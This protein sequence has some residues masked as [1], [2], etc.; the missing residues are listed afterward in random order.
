MGRSMRRSS[1]TPPL[2]TEVQ[3]KVEEALKSVNYKGEALK[4]GE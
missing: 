3:T 4:V 1:D 2:A